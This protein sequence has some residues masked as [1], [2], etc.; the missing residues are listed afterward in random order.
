MRPHA[1][2]TAATV[3]VG[4]YVSFRTLFL[5]G[6]VSQLQ[7]VKRHLLQSEVTKGVS[8]QSTKQKVKA[9]GVR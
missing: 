7:R 2:Y 6:R 5:L 9:V 4:V 1:Q 8:I 3:Q